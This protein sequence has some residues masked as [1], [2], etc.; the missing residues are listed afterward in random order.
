MGQCLRVILLAP[1]LVVVLFCSLKPAVADIPDV[2]GLSTNSIIDCGAPLAGRGFLIVVTVRHTNPTATHYVDKVEVAIGKAT[3][4]IDLK[5]QSTEVFTVTTVVCEGR[6]Y[7]PGQEVTIQARAHCTLHGWGSWS[8]SVTVPEF[9]APT[10]A[11]AVALILVGL[12]TSLVRHGS[13]MRPLPERS[14][15]RVIPRDSW[16]LFHK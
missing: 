13:R 6:D 1:L 5:P 10:V 12:I 3:E 9:G 2:V 15:T 11:A 7:H 14:F 16:H 4:S 8:S